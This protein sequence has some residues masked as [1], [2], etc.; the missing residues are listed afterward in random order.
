MDAPLTRRESH[1]GATHVA[2]GYLRARTLAQVEPHADS[3]PDWK[4][5]EGM[6]KKYGQ[7]EQLTAFSA[8]KE[9]PQQIAAQIAA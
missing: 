7:A 5:V 1:H 6:V 3:A 2:Y 9:I 4:K 8:W